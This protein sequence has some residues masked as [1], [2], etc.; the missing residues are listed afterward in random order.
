MRR[1]DVIR[2]LGG[3]AGATAAADLAH[4]DVPSD[5]ALRVKAIESLLAEAGLVDQADLDSIV[6]VYGQKL[7]PRI[8]A[9]VVARAWVDPAYKQRLL[10]DAWP[11]ITELGL[12]VQGI[13][14]EGVAVVEN[15]A[16]LH[17]LV[18]CTLCS[19]YPWVVLGL[20]PAWYKSEAYRSRAWADPRGVLR[21]LGL[22]LPAG[23]ELRVWDSTANRRYMVL[24]EQPPG[25]DSLNEEALAALVTRDSMIGAAKVLPP[26]SGK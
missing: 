22:E 16:A 13:H 15:T 1:R 23:V 4:A 8:G 18:V 20:A 25:T 26:Q 2:L 21:E 9:R 12:H 11:A 14:D 17:N 7:G 6:E 3:A 19:C 24:P 5:A 10:A